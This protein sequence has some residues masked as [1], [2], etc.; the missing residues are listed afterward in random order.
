MK[1]HKLNP[2]TVFQPP[3]YSQL[4]TV[5]GGKLLVLAG[6]VAWDIDGNIVGGNDLR[7]QT[8]QVFKNIQAILASQNA[9]FANVIKFTIYV[10]DYHP[11]KRND[12][13]EVYQSFVDLDHPPANTLLGVQSLAR[14]GL[15]IEV[16]TIAVVDDPD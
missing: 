10:V 14:E 12:V 5:A 16:E 3:I 6:Q 7:A 1:I 2:D 13:L 9:D 15:L 4:V 8:A 11:D